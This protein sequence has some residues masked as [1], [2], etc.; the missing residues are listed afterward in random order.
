MTGL[1]LA[2]LMNCCC[3][4]IG[5]TMAIISHSI[6]SVSY[7]HLPKEEPDLLATADY[8]E[9]TESNNVAW[10]MYINEDYEKYNICLLYTSI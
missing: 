6:I 10:K 5:A 4:L 8:T 3:K 1:P 2:N 9:Y 7:T